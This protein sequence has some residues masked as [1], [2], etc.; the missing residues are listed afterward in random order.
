MVKQKDGQEFAD[1]KIFFY[2]PQ[3][4]RKLFQKYFF[5]ILFLQSSREYSQNS[6]SNPSKNFYLLFLFFI[7]FLLAKRFRSGTHSFLPD[8]RKNA[9]EKINLKKKLFCQIAQ[10][11]INL[12]N[13]R[14]I[15]FQKYYKNY[16]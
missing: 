3:K 11:L 2:F 10:L 14:L 8:P 4:N 16:F 5:N 6:D 1:K 15:L 9:F 12:V 7:P 13:Y